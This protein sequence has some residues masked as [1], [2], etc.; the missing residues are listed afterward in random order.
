MSWKSNPRAP[1][2]RGA[3]SGVL[4][5]VSLVAGIAGALKR[6]DA[7]YPRPGSS[8]DQIRAFF[9]DNRGAARLA[10]IGQIV[11]AL[12]LGRF[13][14]SIAQMAAR[15]PENPRM[16][17]VTAIA[18]GGFALAAL[19]YSAGANAALTGPAIDSDD[20]TLSLHRRA[21]WA[22]GPLHG[23]G[24]G[25]LMAVL[26]EA[27][28]HTG[29]VPKPVADAALASA[30]ANLLSPLYFVDER[31]AYLIPIGRFSGLVLSATTGARLARGR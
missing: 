27:G 3:L 7:P 12:S 18:G 9:R 24:F 26:G 14:V 15:S 8:V 4:M 5:G 11:S 6:S 20:R 29:E 30:A 1:R 21:F 13:C 22:G 28:R 17:R 16:L 19:G 10:V 25:V 23:A 2:D 31:A